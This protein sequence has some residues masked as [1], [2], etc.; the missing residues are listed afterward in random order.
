MFGEWDAFAFD[1]VT[2]YGGWLTAGVRCCAE[3]VF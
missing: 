3:N 1:G 2:N